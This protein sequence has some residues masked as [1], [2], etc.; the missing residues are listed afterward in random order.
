[1]ES[2]AADLRAMQRTPLADAHVAA[3]RAAGRI[4]T[5]PAGTLMTR[6]G[7]PADT[8]TYVEE[9]EVEVVN[10]YT[11]ERHLPSSLGPTQFMGEIAFLNGG[12]VSMAMRAAQDT[13]SQ[14][15]LDTLGILRARAALA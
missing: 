4:V 3:L 6:P 12:A 2:I 7:E 10:P 14:A 5:Y 13:R 8:F 15:D 9:G 11:D 1:M